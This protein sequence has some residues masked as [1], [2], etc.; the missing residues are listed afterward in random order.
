MKIRIFAKT[1]SRPT[2][3][4]LFRSI[5]SYGIYSVQFNLSLRRPR[6]SSGYCRRQPAL[7][8]A[9][10]AKHSGIGT[11]RSRLRETHRADRDLR[12]NKDL[13]AQLDHI[14]F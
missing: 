7:R 14:R 3:E 5:A 1:F 12:L 8:D 2:I 6:N 13:S 10:D 4:E 9:A 11:D